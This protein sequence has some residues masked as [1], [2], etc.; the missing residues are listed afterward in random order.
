MGANAARH[1]RE[2][3]DNTRTVLAIE[4]LGAAQAVHLRPDGPDR[5]GVGTRAVYDA[6]RECVPPVIE[7]RS[8]AEDVARL[9]AAVD[10]GA[11]ERAAAEALGDLWLPAP[12]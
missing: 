4:L 2:I 5:L 7:D 1:T 12:L 6:V 11:L 9:E 3:L 8:L 10:S